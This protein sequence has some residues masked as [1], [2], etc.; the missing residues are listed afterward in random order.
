ML[1]LLRKARERRGEPAEPDAGCVVW[2]RAQLAEYVGARVGFDEIGKVAE[3][4][5]RV[6]VLQNDIGRP[7]YVIE[8]DAE[9]GK[10]HIGV[11]RDA[12]VGAGVSCI[13]VPSDTLKVV[14]Q[15]TPESMGV[16]NGGLY[17]DMM[18]AARNAAV[19][20]ETIERES[21]EG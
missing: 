18:H 9:I 7:T 10:D 14:A 1:R 20:V 8:V 12:M 13:L 11:L 15:V 6:M 4:V 19:A 3:Y 21:K 2:D 5:E 16:V 17:G